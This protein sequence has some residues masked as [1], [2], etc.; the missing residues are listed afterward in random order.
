MT[1]LVPVWEARFA[2]FL[3]VHFFIVGPMHYSRDP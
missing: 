2:R 3:A 1:I